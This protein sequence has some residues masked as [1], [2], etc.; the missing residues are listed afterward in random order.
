MPRV[1]RDN[2]VNYAII[3]LITMMSQR[4]QERG[5]AQAELHCR[6][7]QGMIVIL[8]SRWDLLEASEDEE[9]VR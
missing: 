1:T 9:L 3:I 4:C 5:L 7:R 2:K 8:F 6:H